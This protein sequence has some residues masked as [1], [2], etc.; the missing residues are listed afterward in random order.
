VVSPSGTT[1]QRAIKTGITDYKNTEVTEGL[2]EGEQVV[3]PK[4]TTTTT[5]TTT[6]RRETG[7]PIFGGP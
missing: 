1:E 3:V 7:I 2:S 6:N 5:S 4:G